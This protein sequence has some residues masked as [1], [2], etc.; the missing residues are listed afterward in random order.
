M[1]AADTG[2]AEGRAEASRWGRA[3]ALRGTRAAEWAW[4]RGSESEG[5]ETKHTSQ[6]IQKGFV[7]L[8]EK[9]GFCSEDTGSHLGILSDR[10]LGV[11]G[12]R[13]SGFGCTELG[14]VQ[15]EV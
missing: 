6:L 12:G 4:S 10:E 9:F 15:V 3:W 11:V 1:R 7:S 13:Q 14:A 8:G 5:R 2:G